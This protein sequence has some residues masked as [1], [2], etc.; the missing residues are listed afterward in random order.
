MKTNTSKNINNLGEVDVIYKYTSSME[1]RPCINDADDAL[2]L[3][4]DLYNINKLGV[5]EQ[6]L[7]LFLNRANCVIG[8]SNLFVGGLTSTVVDIKIV[9]AMAL[10]LL[11]S[12]IL[13]S[14]NHPSGRLIPSE[15]DKNLTKKMQSAL[16]LMDM[17]L[18]DHIIVGP[19][20]SY[21]SF[22]ND[23]IL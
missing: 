17:K 1:N 20:Y 21:L 4:K 23:G 18:L 8:C 13:I 15:E 22:A 7:V 3:L 6:F 10:K 9:L 19:D 14:H 5:Q 2:V 12:S 11:A 16:T